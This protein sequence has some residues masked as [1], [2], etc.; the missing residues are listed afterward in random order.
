[1]LYRGPQFVQLVKGYWKASIMRIEHFSQAVSARSKVRHDDGRL[2]AYSSTFANLE[3]T[4][5]DGLK[6]GKGET[7][8]AGPRREIPLEKFDKRI[9]PRPL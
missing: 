4:V 5:P 7:L 2:V 6:V 8:N 3:P 1:M 9:D